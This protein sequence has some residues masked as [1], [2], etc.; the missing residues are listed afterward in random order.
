MSRQADLEGQSAL[1]TGATSGIGKSVAECLGRYGA[2]VIVHGRD[3]DRGAAAVESVTSLGGTARFVAADLS[4]PG[5]LDRL[6]AEAEETDILVNNA[7]FSWFGPTADLDMMTFDRL[8]AAR[9]SALLSCRSV[10]TENGSTW[11]GKHR[12]HEQHGRADRSCRWRCLW[13][14]QGHDDIHDSVVGS[15]VP[16]CRRTSQCH[17]RRSGLYRWLVTRPHRDAGRH[18]SHE[19]RCPSG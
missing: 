14:H 19:A 2:N 7:G 6:V 9:Q 13:C 11:F 5:D 1:V 12:Q 17:R 16:P 4:D 3:A 15:G 8:F 18:H 10:G